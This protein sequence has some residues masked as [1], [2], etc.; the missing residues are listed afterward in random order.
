MLVKIQR[1]S[2][3][4]PH[5]IMMNLV[6]RKSQWNAVKY[7]KG[8]MRL[9]HLDSPSSSR[10]GT[11]TGKTLNYHKCSHTPDIVLFYR[12]C[13]WRDWSLSAE[14]S[15]S[16]D[17]HMHAIGFLGKDATW[18]LWLMADGNLWRKTL[19]LKIRGRIRWKATFR[20]IQIG[21]RG[22]SQRVNWKMKMWWK[23]S[24]QMEKLQYRN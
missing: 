18:Q 12:D 24:L 1:N 10:C 13:R 3:K 22:T 7:Q 17:G 20:L 23:Q 19:W 11:K 5:W 21:L 2:S 9:H 14:N 16:I 4:N 6:Y 8:R 15:G